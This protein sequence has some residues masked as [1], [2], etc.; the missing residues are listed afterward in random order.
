MQIYSKTGKLT[1]SEDNKN[2]EIKLLQHMWDVL[3]AANS[4]ETGATYC[5]FQR[6]LFAIEGLIFLSHNDKYKDCKQLFAEF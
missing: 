3:L 1:V 2:D 6:F 4:S 5:S